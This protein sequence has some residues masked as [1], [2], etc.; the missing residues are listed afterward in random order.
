MCGRSWRLLPK[1]RQSSALSLNGRKKPIDQLFD[2]FTDQ[3]K[4]RRTNISLR[5]SV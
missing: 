2:G 1:R 5:Q 3:L 4:V